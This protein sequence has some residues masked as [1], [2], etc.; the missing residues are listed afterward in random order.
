MSETF[1]AK[2]GSFEGPLETLL[3]LIKRRELPINEISLARVTDDY[4]DYITEN[5]ETLENKADFVRTASTLLLAKSKAL[6]PDQDIEDEEDIDE[7]E[8]RLRAYQLI[9]NRQE[10]LEDEFSGPSHRFLRPRK[11]ASFKEFVPGNGL[12]LKKLAQKAKKL[13]VDLPD[14]S[15]P[16]G[17]IKDTVSIGD[18]ISRLQT[19]CKRLGPVKLADIHRS[20]KKHHRVV[21]FI[22][23]LE[24][25]K[26]G[27]IQ[28]RQRKLF[29]DIMLKKS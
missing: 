11:K 2:T 26:A 1:H 10:K 14:E 29:G 18:E 3:S 21:S 24:L 4:I 13:I 12:T 7:L 22:A 17:N 27:E 23:T 5:E 8:D 9:K 15:L 16:T 28:V 6:L 25:A 20:K 19:H